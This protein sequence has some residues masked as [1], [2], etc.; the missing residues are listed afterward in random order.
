MTIAGKPRKKH[1][2]LRYAKQGISSV[3]I[4][5]VVFLGR[6]HGPSATSGGGRPSPSPGGPVA[7]PGNASAYGL[8]SEAFR[9]VAAAIDLTTFDLGGATSTSRI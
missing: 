9:D 6:R 3:I 1:T 4:D 5:Y 8:S 7:V 2:T